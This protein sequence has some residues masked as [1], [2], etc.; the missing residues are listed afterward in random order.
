[1]ESLYEMCARHSLIPRSL[2]IELPHNPTDAPAAFGGLGDVWKSEYCGRE[3]AVKVM[4]MYRREN[5]ESNTRV[6]C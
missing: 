3:V 2:G 1:M 4:R 5:L 6:S